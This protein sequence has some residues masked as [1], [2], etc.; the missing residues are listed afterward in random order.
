VH[1]R[2]SGAPEGSKVC[3]PKG[4]V[5]KDRHKPS[6]RVQ[7]GEALICG[8]VPL[9]GLGGAVPS[10]FRQGAEAGVSSLDSVVGGRGMSDPADAR[11]ALLTALLAVRAGVVIGSLR[12]GKYRLQVVAQA[13][14]QGED[15]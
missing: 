8:A 15:I 11:W 9:G 13:P 7:L 6:P 3:G 4:R 12:L 5:K 14:G 10:A 2:G 1:L